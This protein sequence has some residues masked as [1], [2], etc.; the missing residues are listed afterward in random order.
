MFVRKWQRIPDLPA[1]SVGGSIV[2][3]HES[4]LLFGGSMQSRQIIYAQ[5]VNKICISNL[6]A[7]INEVIDATK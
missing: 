3:F 5:Q 1:A 2:P 6:F 7:I 4:V